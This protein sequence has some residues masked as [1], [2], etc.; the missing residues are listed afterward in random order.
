MRPRGV[1]EGVGEKAHLSLGVSSQRRRPGWTPVIRSWGE[2]VARD[3]PG[4]AVRGAR[5]VGTM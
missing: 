1:R 2:G 4:R 3:A 5:A